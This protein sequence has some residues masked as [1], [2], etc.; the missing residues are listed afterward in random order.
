M[1]GV[2]IEEK[3]SARGMMHTRKESIK[4]PI[5]YP[6][7]APFGTSP[8]SLR[9]KIIK[10]R[11]HLPWPLTLATAGYFILHF[12]HFFFPSCNISIHYL[13]FLAINIE[14]FL[15]K[16]TASTYEIWKLTLSLIQGVKTTKKQQ[17]AKALS[18]FE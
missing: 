4:Y 18:L 16:I 12:Y 14:A 11:C 3:G 8:V 17:R 5:S 13:L 6:L 2:G 15:N 9:L 10:G 7:F 1:D